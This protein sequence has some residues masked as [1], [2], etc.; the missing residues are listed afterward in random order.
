MG[1]EFIK[2]GTSNDA[3]KVVEEVEALFIGNCAVHILRVYVVMADDELGVL[4]VL[5]KSLYSILCNIELA[6]CE[7]MSLCETYQEPSSR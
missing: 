1:D 3:F 7:E 2:V 4:M 6:F 5:T